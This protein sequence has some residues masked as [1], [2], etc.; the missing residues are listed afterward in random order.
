M[1]DVVR[2][3]ILG[4]T[5]LATVDETIDPAMYAGQFVRVLP[6][7]NATDEGLRKLKIELERAGALAVR[8]GP[9]PHV[10]KVQLGNAAQSVKLMMSDDD[11]MPPV[12]ELVSS[13]IATSSSNRKSELEALLMSIA[14][15]EGL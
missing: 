12:R 5:R 4:S 3:K 6:S 1:T 11:K 14:D 8:I 7:V 10:G 15:K 13:L 2:K 9:K